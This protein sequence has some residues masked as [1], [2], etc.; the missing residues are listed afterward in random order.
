VEES[1]KYRGRMLE[2]VELPQPN[3]KIFEIARRAPGV[4][5]IIQ[6]LDGAKLLITKEYRHETGG[7]DYRLPGGK[8]FDTIVEY[9][10]YITAGW[11]LMDAAKSKAIEEGRQETGI[12]IKELQYLL[13][14]NC[15]ATV[16]WDLYYFEVTEWTIR[17]GGQ[18][19]EQGEDIVCEWMSIAD[20]KEILFK[21]ELQ[22]YRSVGVLTQWLAG[23][24]HIK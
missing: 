1:I 8:V 17:A 7:Y 4:R 22:E 5:L 18:E 14:A 2:I 19:L 21:G 11:S 15:G 16:E 3:G 6:A 9:D 23:K 24:G 20:V 10:D 12:D 13:T